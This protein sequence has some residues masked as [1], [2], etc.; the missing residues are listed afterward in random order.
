VAVTNIVAA[1]VLVGATSD[2]HTSPAL[3]LAYTAAYVVG[4]AISYAVLRRRLGGLESP[5][6]LRFLVRLALVVLVSTG[7]ALLVALGLH[8]LSERPPW[9]VAAAQAAAITA[10]DVVVFV[11]LARALRLREVTSVI[12]TVTRRLSRSRES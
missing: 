11:L 5:R 1:M 4:S 7:V 9:P 12:E 3:V 10:V 8:D 2:E 6:L